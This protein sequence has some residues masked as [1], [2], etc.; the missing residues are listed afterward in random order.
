[1]EE[2]RMQRSLIFIT[3]LALS[4]AGL[5]WL[6]LR[7]RPA[8]FPAYAHVGAPPETTPLPAGLPAPV[9]RFYRQLYGEQVPV[10]RSAVISGRGTMRPVNGGPTLPMRFRFTHEAGR[11]YRH[12][13]EATFFGL[14]IMRVN[15]HFVDGKERMELPWATAEGPT[16]DQAGNLGMWGES[17]SWLPAILLTDPRVR[18]EPVDAT[19]A[20]L[21][22]PFDDGEERFVIRFDPTSG[23]LQ[24]MEALRYK[25]EE[26]VKTLWIGTAADWQPL[27]T[28]AA[29]ARVGSLTWLDEGTPWAHF[30]VEAIVYNAAVDAS[31]E[32]RGP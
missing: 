10:I 27:G 9:E 25:G 8:P 29:A 19:T 1:M 26:P 20:I 32:A 22:V 17:I 12:Y 13:I 18:W 4:L 24:L 5:G 3:G 6:G 14:P 2:H 23:M 16:Y 11:N 30:E 15:E 28:P 7:I 31:L 21:V